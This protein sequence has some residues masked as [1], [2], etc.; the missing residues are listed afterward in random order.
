MEREK[1][2]DRSGEQGKSLRDAPVTCTTRPTTS[3]G[4]SAGHTSNHSLLRDSRRMQKPR[5]SRISSSS[6]SGPGRTAREGAAPASRGGR[7]RITAGDGGVFGRGCT[8][9]SPVLPGFGGCERLRKKVENGP[10][11][12]GWNLT[13]GPATPGAGPVDQMST[14]HLKEDAV[15]LGPGVLATSRAGS[16]SGEGHAE[17]RCESASRSDAGQVPFVPAAPEHPGPTGIVIL[18]FGADR[19]TDLG[20]KLV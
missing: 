13:T 16:T 11:G 1:G 4:S 6:S 2:P 19:V 20:R 17:I 15:S 9:I 8:G 3:G 14:P 5:Q 18:H 12:P 10:N 7:G